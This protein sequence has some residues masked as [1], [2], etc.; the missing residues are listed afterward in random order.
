[1]KTRRPSLRLWG[2]RDEDHHYTSLTAED[3]PDGGAQVVVS[4]HHHDG[5]VGATYSLQLTPRE[6]QQLASFLYYGAGDHR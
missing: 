6:R 2:Y 4:D 5:K 1:M 3:L